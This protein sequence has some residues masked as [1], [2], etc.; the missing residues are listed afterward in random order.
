MKTRRRLKYNNKHTKKNLMGGMLPSSCQIN[1]NFDDFNPLI[2]ELNDNGIHPSTQANLNCCWINSSLYAFLANYHVY[3]ILEQRDENSFQIQQIEDKDPHSFSELADIVKQFRDLG[4]NPPHT[5][6]RWDASNYYTLYELIQNK[7]NFMPDDFPNF[8]EYGDA[9]IIFELFLNLF[10]RRTIPTGKKV[11]KGWQKLI[12][13]HEYVNSPQELCNFLNSIEGYTCVS[14]TRTWRC[15][16][17]IESSAND[18]EFDAFHFIA[19]ARVNKN[20]WRFFDSG[21]TIND[22]PLAQTLLAPSLYYNKLTNACPK[23][24]AFYI[25]GLFIK[26]SALTNNSSK[27]I[28]KLALKPSIPFTNVG[29]SE[30]ENQLAIALKLSM[31]EEKRIEDEPEEIRLAKLAAMYNDDTDD[32]DDIYYTDDNDSIY[33]TENTKPSTPFG[34]GGPDES[35]AK[36]E[37]LRQEAAQAQEKEEQKRIALQKRI[38]D[39]NKAEREEVE[40]IA[41][42]IRAKQEEERLISEKAKTERL[43]AEK[44]EAERIL[45]EKKAEAERISRQKEAYEWYLKREQ[46]GFDEANA[47]QKAEEKRI[48]NE[49]ASAE[50]KRIIVA[51]AAEQRIAEEQKRITQEQKRIV[52]EKAAQEQIIVYEKAAEEQRISDEKAA[53]EQER[54]AEEQ[55]RIEEEQ[56]RIAEEKAAEEKRIADEKATEEKRIADEKAAEEKRIAEKEQ[57][58]AE[59]Q[60]RIAD[61]EAAKE[62]ERIAAEKLAKEQRIAAEK[63]AEE[64][65]IAEEKKQIE[66]QRAEEKRIEAERAEAERIAADKAEEL[67]ILQE[68]A[69]QE[70]KRIAEEEAQRQI[71]AKKDEEKTMVDL[72]QQA[73]DNLINSLQSKSVNIQNKILKN[74]EDKKKL[75]SLQEDMTN[76]IP[77]ESSITQKFVSPTEKIEKID[78]NNYTFMCPNKGCSWEGNR[79]DLES[80]LKICPYNRKISRKQYIYDKNMEDFENI[81]EEIQSSRIKNNKWIKKGD[82]WVRSSGTLED[83]AALRNQQLQLDELK[84]K[85]LKQKASEY[86]KE[87]DP[88]IEHDKL[89]KQ[90]KSKEEANLLAQKGKKDYIEIDKGDGIIKTIQKALPKINIEEQK[91]LPKPKKWPKVDTTRETTHEASYWICKYCKQA[92]SSQNKL[93]ASCGTPKGEFVP[94]IP[95]EQKNEKTPEEKAQE[96]ESENLLT[97][98]EEMITKPMPK[99]PILEIPIEVPPYPVERRSYGH[100][101]VKPFQV[102]VESDYDPDIFNYLDIKAGETIIVIGKMKNDR[103]VTW[104]YGYKFGSSPEYS[105]K[106]PTEYLSSRVYSDSEPNWMKKLDHRYYPKKKKTQVKSQDKS[107]IQFTKGEEVFYQKSVD[108]KVLAKI[109][110][111]H[112]DD[113]EPYYTIRLQDGSEKQTIY[114]RLTKII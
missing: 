102:V 66:A 39:R 38:N 63:A 30:E 61:E 8:G 36:L 46:Q 35:R 2:L 21:N 41:S 58:I 19:Y 76:I 100:E 47:L 92:N 29:K 104:L 59:E 88:I 10:E 3:N 108:Q 75:L 111:I 86:H 99:P 95:Q 81:E 9:R 33:T 7:Y 42:R 55:K 109:I 32:T 93:C 27:N 53:E 98:I 69:E 65:R 113:V 34:F 62:E 13:S 106:F 45:A 96:E 26:N 14:F 50:E 56:K 11:E 18:E 83:E 79:K 89:Y 70:Q 85:R 73:T 77:K 40:R 82:K 110:K 49:K 68:K 114:N 12:G 112:H 72:Q 103:N 94:P 5:A 78:F 87:I 20:K 67:R 16:D 48:E 80:H 71:K 107:N 60:K 31:D 90:D 44:S 54:I 97:N 1:D 51:N 101:S 84:R 15:I 23:G 64:Q 17:R 22:V 24:K 52:E 91:S 105:G 57:R 28:S 43:A 37:Q 4:D 74:K 6:T 25:S